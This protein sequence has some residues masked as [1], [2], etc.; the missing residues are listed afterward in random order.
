MHERKT[1]G[2]RAGLL[3][4]AVAFFG[5]QGEP[6]PPVDG[7]AV[8]GDGVRAGD[9]ACDDGAGNSDIEP[10]AC[11][12]GCEAPRCG[13]GVVDPEE[14]CDDGNVVDGDGCRANCRP[15]RAV[16]V[17]ASGTFTC[18]LFEEGNVRCWGEEIGQVLGN[19]Y[20]KDG[21]YPEEYPTHPRPAGVFGD[22]D[23]GGRAVKLSLGGR[24]AC[25]L[26]DSG[27][28]RCWGWRLAEYP[29][30]DVGDNVNYVIGDEA[31]EMP[32]PDLEARGPAVDLFNSCG[33]TCALLESNDVQCWY[34]DALT[35]GCRTPSAAYVR[36]KE[37]GEVQ[38]LTGGLVSCVLYEAGNVKCW[39]TPDGWGSAYLGYGAP[40]PL[41]P[42]GTYVLLVSYG[43]VDLGGRVTQ[44]IPRGPGACALRDTGEVY[45]WGWNADGQLGYGH[46]EAIGDDET[47]VSVGPVPL[48][49]RVTQI[50]GGGGHVCVLLETGRVRCWGNLSNGALG[51]GDRFPRRDADD[52][53]LTLGDEPG[54]MPPP[55]VDIGGKVIQISAG[56]HHTCAVLEDGGIRCWGGGDWGYDSRLLGYGRSVSLDDPP[57]L[58]GDVPLYPTPLPPAGRQ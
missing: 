27:Q 22:L 42:G 2:V 31:G 19:G 29:R 38:Q 47:P 26:L 17:E 45:C 32:P 34:P 53:P 23:L 6:V 46:R 33:G 13:D 49:G 24:H 48:G 36:A 58:A 51:Y 39:S 57:A 10:G 55:D 54:E 41:D 9:E 43:D 7:G 3:V 5:C 52:R 44:I 56:A 20:G 15:P 25:A 50:A 4:L 35:D 16:Q 11:R 1:M 21:N 37:H 40:V 28:V 30:Y 8:C 12:L 18:A 14:Y